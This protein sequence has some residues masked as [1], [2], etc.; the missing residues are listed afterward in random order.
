LVDS[1][2]CAAADAM[3][4]TPEAVRPALR[5]AFARARD[6]RLTTAEVA[7]AL[8]PPDGVTSR[9]GQARRKRG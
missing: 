3:S 7:S 8:A 1:I 4:A 6:L 9:Q 2:T 5:A